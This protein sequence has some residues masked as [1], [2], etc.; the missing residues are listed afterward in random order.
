MKVEPR[1][2]RAKT[3]FF[4]WNS[5]EEWKDGLLGQSIS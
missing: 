2:E 3:E 5:K 1:M 4:E